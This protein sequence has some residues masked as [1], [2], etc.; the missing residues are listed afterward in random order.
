[1]PGI[2]QGHLMIL[3]AGIILQSGF[4]FLQPPDRV[5]K[6]EHI[7]LSDKIG[8]HGLIG[9]FP[10]KRVYRYE[11]HQFVR[12]AR[13]VGDNRTGEGMPEQLI[14]PAVADLIIHMGKFRLTGTWFCRKYFSCWANA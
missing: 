10:L 7:Q 12:Q 3:S 11:M 9:L 14:I 1:M 13:L 8:L 2:K 5:F 6:H 4:S